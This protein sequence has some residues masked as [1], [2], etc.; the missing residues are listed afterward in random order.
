MRF[1]TVPRKA[2][3]VVEPSA[4]AALK[5]PASMMDDGPH[6]LLSRIELMA[7]AWLRVHEFRPL[8]YAER[9]Q[10]LPAAYR[11]HVA[12][13]VIDLE[14]CAVCGASWPGAPRD[15][16]VAGELLRVVGLHVWESIHAEADFR[17]WRRHLT[18]WQEA[19]RW[20]RAVDPAHEGPLEGVFC[21]A[22]RLFLLDPL[23]LAEG[24]PHRHEL[25]AGSGML[26]P[27][28]EGWRSVLAGAPGQVLTAIDEWLGH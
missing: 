27:H 14:R 13:A 19:R 4:R 28:D 25:L 17:S 22:F 5:F 3:Q 11:P 15:D 23:L 16:S 12:E 6:V 1:T 24:R 20:E 7:D 10:A 2:C 18:A 9:S 8:R 26:P 21:E